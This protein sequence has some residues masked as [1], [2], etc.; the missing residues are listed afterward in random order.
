[1]RVMN[2]MRLITRVYGI[3]I[4]HALYKSAALRQSGIVLKMAVGRKTVLFCLL[5]AV[6]QRTVG[7]DLHVGNDRPCQVPGID[8]DTN[9]DEDNLSCPIIDPTVI[10]CYQRAELCNTNSFCGEGS[11]EGVNPAFKLTS[12]YVTCDLRRPRSYK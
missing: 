7:Q 1:M 5:L 4:K 9:F 3:Y 10:Q 8:P 12:A 6:V 11:D 2:N